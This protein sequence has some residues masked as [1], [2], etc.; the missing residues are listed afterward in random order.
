MFEILMESP[1]W[2]PIEGVSWA[3]YLGSLAILFVTFVFCTAIPKLM[4]GRALG[5][6]RKTKTD[7]DDRILDFLKRPIRY[8]GLL[9]G[10]YFA[11]VVLEPSEARMTPEVAD[12]FRW[13][14]A[15]LS[16]GFLIILGIFLL[17]VIDAVALV[18]K[19]RAN[20]TESKLDDQ[21]V[22]LVRK[23]LKTFTVILLAVVFIQNLGYSVSGFVA[24]LGL[25]GLAFALA[26]KDTVANLFGSLTIFTDQPFQVGDWVNSG[27]VSGTVEEVGFRSTRLRKAD[28][29]VV[30]IPNASI[31]MGTVH[32][33]SRREKRRIDI[34][35]GLTY[36]CTPEKM[37]TF[38]EKVRNLL[39]EDPELDDSGRAHFTGFAP[40][41]LT[42]TICAHTK[43]PD[44]SHFMTVRQELNLNLMRLCQEVGVE[45][46]FDSRT[47][48]LKST[49]GMPLPQG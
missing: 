45:M 38:I 43:T 37:V 9:A 27:S 25:G 29:T 3:R 35:I 23:T 40:S 17:A 44:F 32:N 30:S 2:S 6:T 12:A 21:L 14:H 8:L 1:P 39:D 41:S 42:V 24:G 13:V 49:E 5:F 18:L 26:A 11:V 28:N 19:A 34:T 48:Y 33:A 36:D 46:A 20:R 7:L 16:G 47:V 15:I 4:I 10:I 31:A 22:P